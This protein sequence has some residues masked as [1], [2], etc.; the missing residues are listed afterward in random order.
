MNFNR[1]M[2]LLTTTAAAVAP[3]FEAYARE[4][5]EM[6]VAP[7]GNVGIMRR[8]PR[9]DLES[10]HNFLVGQRQWQQGKL[11]KAGA[12]RA[13]EILK[14]NGLNPDSDI[15]LATLMPLFENDPVIALNGRAF[16]EIQ[17][18]KFTTLRDE[19]H[20]N[21]D[22]YYAELEAADKKGPGTLEMSPKMHIPDYTKHE[23]HTQIGGYVGDPFA[24]Y[25]YNY[26]TN[27]FFGGR[28]D[29]DE[30]YEGMAAATPVPTDKK[31]KRILDIG[32]GAGQL[33]TSLKKRFPEAEVWA[34][35]V[36]APMIRYGHM[37][38]NEMGRDINFAQRL[39]EDSKFPDGHFDIVAS[40]I[41]FHE[42]TAD[43]SR[44]IIKEVSRVLRPGGVFYPVD[45][46]TANPPPSR[47][48]GRFTS[49]WDHRW[50][51]EVWR[52]E[53]TNLDFNGAMKANNLKIGDGPSSGRAERANVMATKA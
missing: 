1:R 36:G 52:M 23:I 45:F 6:S 46:Y 47:P 3:V 35:D 39:A 32:C 28:N 27:V 38:A 29:Q 24:G 30:L 21:A 20:N 31:V 48:I 2:A 33:A 42:V 5:S 18:L 19:V 7:R 49:W 9:L 14:A 4:A 40:Y 13:T 8:L 34:I 10:Y 53:Y 26:G 50:N 44:N 41:M 17:R 12:A 22:A 51:N 43:A 11:A 25:I 37:R 15:P 16:L